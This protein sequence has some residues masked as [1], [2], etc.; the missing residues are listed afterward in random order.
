VDK[1]TIKDCTVFHN[2]KGIQRTTFYVPIDGRDGN[3]T[4]LHINIEMI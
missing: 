1:T 4:N 3:Y 2:C